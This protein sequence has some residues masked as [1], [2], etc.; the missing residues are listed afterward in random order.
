M[1]NRRSLNKLE[2]ETLAK[3]LSVKDR[4][5]YFALVGDPGRKMT[6]KEA[7]NWL[8]IPSS[9]TSDIVGKLLRAR[10]IYKSKNER[11]NVLYRKVINHG[12]VD[13]HVEADL[14]H[15]ANGNADHLVVKDG[16]RCH[17]EVNLIR[18]HLAGA[19]IDITVVKEGN[20][21]GFSNE[22]GWIG[23]FDG[24]KVSWPNGLLKRSAKTYIDG[25]WT[26]IRY[27]TGVRT[28]SKT[29]GIAPGHILTSSSDLK[30]ARD[31]ILALFH[32]R[33]TPFL[34]HME[35]YGGWVFQKDD[36]GYYVFKGKPKPE[37]GFDGNITRLLKQIEVNAGV[38]GDALYYD[39]SKAAGSEGEFETSNIDMATAL[40]DLPETTMRVSKLESEIGSLK[41]KVDTLVKK[42]TEDAE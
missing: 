25:K 34:C 20:L 8:G 26:A 10:A 6:Q 31:D 11:T 40:A 5:V 35:K 14:S 3:N 33:I 38:P 1:N 16:V 12:I 28:G 19:W 21:D 17:K 36:D 2:A 24:C 23:L 39:T 22:R 15:G 41:E 30:A 18:T 7:S 42:R 9:T 4:M 13:A 37:F 27:Q 32:G 29:F